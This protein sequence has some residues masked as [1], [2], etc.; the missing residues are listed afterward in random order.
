MLLRAVTR[1]DGPVEWATVLALLT[2]AVMVVRHMLAPPP[3]LGKLYRAIAWGLVVVA[4]LAAGEEISWGQRLFGFATGETMKALNH[5]QETNLHNLMPGEL[6]NGL[7]VFALGIGFVLLPAIWR[8]KTASPPLW[9]PSEEVSLLMLVALLVNHYV[10]RSLPEQVGIVVLLALLAW[11][12]GRAALAKN[13]A[14]LMAASAGWLT[15]A[16]L[17]HT[18]AILRAANHQYEIRELL[19]VMLAIVWAEQTFQAYRDREPNSVP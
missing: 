15:A 3:A 18:R 4:L 6:F 14:M 1:E 7:I 16:C 9:L 8:S 10:F 13:R 17:Y 19:I 2:L 12:T 11:E 5:Q